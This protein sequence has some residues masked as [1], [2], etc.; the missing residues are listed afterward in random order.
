MNDL[1]QE[2]VYGYDPYFGVIVERANE[3]EIIKEQKKK[4]VIVAQAKQKSK[5]SSV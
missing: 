2:V 4:E 1:I 3:L 5:R